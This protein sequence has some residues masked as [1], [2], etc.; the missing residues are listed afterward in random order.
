MTDDIKTNLGEIRAFTEETWKGLAI[1]AGHSAGFFNILKVDT[2]I[3][4]DDLA[5]QKGYDVGKVEKWI[6]FAEGAGI[7]K[8]DNRKITLTTKGLLISSGSPIRDILAFVEGTTYFIKAAGSAETTFK[9]NQSFDKL[10]DGKISKDYQPR[11]SDNLSA[12]LVT[13]LKEHKLEDN[14]KLLDFGCGS[15]SFLRKLYE[16][17]PTLFYTGVDVNLFSV[18]KGKK[19]NIALGLTDRIK[20]L[21]GDIV[22]DINDFPDNSYEWVT[23]INVLHFVPLDKRNILI[24]NLI[25]IARKGVFFNLVEAESSMIGLAGNMLMHLLWSDFTGFYTKNE[26]QQI[27]ADLPKINKNISVQTTSILQGN[28]ILVSVLKK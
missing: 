26:I 19:E 2:P 21:V 15:G 5:K 22:E 8:N 25:R 14:D 1:A 28:S 20:M 24:H 6:S 17:I 9:V 10:S 12:A 13:H 7:V 3:S 16:A 4:V 18:E 11:V 23:F 27:F